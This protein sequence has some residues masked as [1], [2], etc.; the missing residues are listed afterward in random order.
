[1]TG[2]P[3]HVFAG[4]FLIPTFESLHNELGVVLGDVV[5]IIGNATTHEQD[6]VGLEEIEELDDGL[7]VVDELVEAHA[8]GEAGAGSLGDEASD[9]GILVAGPALQLL[10]RLLREGLEE[11][12]D[13][14]LGGEALGHVEEGVHGERE[15]FLAESVDADVVAEGEHG[16]VGSHDLIGLLGRSECVDEDAL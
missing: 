2:D 15:V 5:E 13:G 6:G 1:M 4:G 16:E 9:V 10:E 8:P 12:P 7:W 11:G 3:V 14:E